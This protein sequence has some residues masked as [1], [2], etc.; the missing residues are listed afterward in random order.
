MPANVLLRQVGGLRGDAEKIIYATHEHCRL[1]V[2]QTTS[3]A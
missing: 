1:R 3:H 2:V